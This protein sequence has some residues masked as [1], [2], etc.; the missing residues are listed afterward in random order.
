MGNMYSVNDENMSWNDD[1]K[2]VGPAGELIK[3][4]IG[5]IGRKTIKQYWHEVYNG[6][7]PVHT[8]KFDEYMYNDDFHKYDWDKLKNS[9]LENGYD[10][11]KYSPI[12]VKPS[13]QEFKYAIIDG[14]HRAFLLREMFGEDYMID[15]DLRDNNKNKERKS[16][17]EY[18]E[19]VNTWIYPLYFFVFHTIT[20]IIS[21]ILFYAIQKYLPNNQLYKTLKKGKLLTKINNFSDRLYTIVLNIV[22]NTQMISYIIV[23]ISVSLYMLFTDFYGIIA[24]TI[25]TNLVKYSLSRFKKE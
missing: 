13:Y 8:N 16:I 18:V 20:M 11:Y 6:I 17:I 23:A 2:S 7:K 9:L 21:V 25:F 1:R 10:I 19:L 5:D 4:R 3:V 22:N 15:V 24:I 12:T 14:Q